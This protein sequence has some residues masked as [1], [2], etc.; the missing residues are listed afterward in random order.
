MAI[1]DG[2]EKLAV[3]GIAYRG[4]YD[5]GTAYG[6]LNAVY[7]GGSTFVALKDSPAGPPAADGANWQYL[8][9]GFMEGVMEAVTVTDTKGIVGEAGSTVNAQSFMDA[10]ADRVE[11]K[12][13]AK[14]QLVNNLL[15]TEPGNP[16]D[17]AV[18]PVITQMISEINSNL[19]NLFKEVSGSVRKDS[20]EPLAIADMSI[21]FDVPSGYKIF[22][23][24]SADIT[25]WSGLVDQ[26]C[27]ISGNTVTF[28]VYST[29]SS[30]VPCAVSATVNC[31]KI[32]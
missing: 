14:S 23:V 31:I 9:Q 4:D 15:A 16:M 24:K 7:Y 1:P 5:E 28:K 32:I 17:A 8:A 12:L 18:G 6:K 30:A 21:T 3:I 22:S 13:L 11:D 25:G 26:G 19:K 2:Y 10:V 29:R 20:I 27:R